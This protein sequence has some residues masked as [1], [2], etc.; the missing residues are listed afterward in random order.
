VFGK[1]STY[2]GYREYENPESIK[3]NYKNYVRDFSSLVT[4]NDYKAFLFNSQAKTM[5]EARLP[6]CFTDISLQNNSFYL[7][8]IS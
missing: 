3:I 4:K 5:N 1:I 7:F 6:P 8:F 2:G